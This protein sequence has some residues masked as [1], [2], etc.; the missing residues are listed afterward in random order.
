MKILKTLF[1]VLLIII[2]TVSCSGDDGKDGIDGAPGT[3][4]VIYSGWITA[5]AGTPET[6]DA[7]S[8]LSTTIDVPEL[9]ADIL[10]KG[11]ILAYMSFGAGT[12]IYKLPYTSTAG[13]SVNTIT[14]ISSLGKIKFFRFSM[15]MM[16]Q[17]LHFPHHLIGVMF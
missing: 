5:P 4:N 17:Q 13:G 9:S 11:T 12:N 1:T 2:F 8:G 7:T 10:S 3:A 15:L 16:E 6:I 14:A